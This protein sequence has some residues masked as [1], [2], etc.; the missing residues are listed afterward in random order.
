VGSLFCNAVAPIICEKNGLKVIILFILYI[1]VLDSALIS[2]HMVQYYY[3]FQ[4]YISAIVIIMALAVP[5]PF[6]VDLV[7]KEF[8]RRLTVKYS[9]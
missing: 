8:Q 4:G 7:I 3:I 5:S 2:F 6:S 1:I 9:S